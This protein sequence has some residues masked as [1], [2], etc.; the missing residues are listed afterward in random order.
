MEFLICVENARR[1]EWNNGRAHCPVAFNNYIHWFLGSTRVSICPPSY[2]EEILEEPVQFDELA[3]TQY[4][5]QVRK[6][7]DIPLSSSL[8]F[9]RTEV[10]KYADDAEAILF[11][12]PKGKKGEGMIR[13]F[14]K[15]WMRDFLKIGMF[16]F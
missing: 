8:N 6:G 1:T 16:L 14:L 13:D 9:A 12:A 7:T 10:K 5:R 15:V 11:A 4:N 2:E 3:Y